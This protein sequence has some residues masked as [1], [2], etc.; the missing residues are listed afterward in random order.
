[1]KKIFLILFLM[2]FLIGTISALDF[3]NVAYYNENKKDVSI[4][5]AF[6]LPLIGY[7]IA[8][9]NLQTSLT[10]NFVSPGKDVIVFQMNIENYADYVNALKDLKIINMKNGKQEDKSYKWVY[11][12]YENID[13][14]DYDIKCELIPQAGKLPKEVCNKVIIGKHKENIIV[15]WKELI[16]K[17]LPKGNITIGLMTDVEEGDHYD[18]IPTLFGK[19]L[20]EWVEWTADLNTN[21]VHYWKLDDGNSTNIIDALY[22]VNGTKN[23]ATDPYNITGKIASAQY[24]HTNNYGINFSSAYVKATN[25]S[26]SINFWLYTVSNGG[27]YGEF[28]TSGHTGTKSWAVTGSGSAGANIKLTKN[29]L[30]EYSCVAT[31]TLNQ[32]TMV[33]ITMAPNGASNGNL[34]YYING[35]ANCSEIMAP[36]FGSTSN[37]GHI[38]DVGSGG[39]GIVASIDEIGIWVNRTLSASDINTLWNGGNGMSYIFFSPGVPVITLNSPANNYNSSSNS[40][41]FNCTASSSIYKIQNISL[42]INNNRNYTKTYGTSNF[43]ELNITRNFADGNFN[44]TCSADNNKTITDTGWAG[45]NRT[46]NIDTIKPIINIT[47]PINYIKYI[48]SGNN[49]SL[50]WS[51]SDSH[52]QSC[53]YTYNVTANISVPCSDNSTNI[54]VTSLSINNATIWANDTF[55]NIA[56]MS[57]S[58]YYKVFQ[59]NVSYS[60]TTT[61][62]AT[63]SFVLD[64]NQGGGLQTSIINLIYNTTSYS[65]TY[66]VS[67]NNVY[68]SNS[69]AIPNKDEAIIVPFYWKIILSDGSIINTTQYNQ[70]VSILSLDNC[71]DFSTVIYNYTLFDEETQNKLSNNIVELQ[72]NWYDA[73]KTV[74]ILNFSK[75]YEEE[76]KNILVCFNSSLLTNINYSVDSVVRYTSNDSGNSYSIKYYNILNQLITN[77]TIP[78]NVKLYDL[79]SSKSTEFQL[80]YKDEKLAFAPNILIYVYRQYV[81]DNDFK[82]VEIPL[83]DSNGQ[84]VLHLVRN[85]VIYNFVMINS[86]GDIVATFNRIIAFCQDY[87]IGSCSI[88]LNAVSQ[89]ERMY[90]YLDDLG[91]SYTTPTYS[92]TTG[93]ISFEFVSSNLS[94]VTTEMQVVRNNQFGNRSV[95]SNSFTSSSGTVSCNVSGVSATDRYL[96]IDIYVNGDLKAETT[97]DLEQSSTGG[98]GIV[99][100]AFYGFLLLLLMIC[101]FMDDKQGLVIALGIGWVLIIALTM[102]NGA[103]I[104]SI[105]GGIWL[106]LTIIMFIWK[107]KKEETG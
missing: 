34:T 57:R 83:T 103:I 40:V 23:I 19:E 97:I 3:D 79:L 5:N 28:L 10:D 102:I 26:F 68:S 84:T 31:Y 78:K 73:S 63:E 98:F 76:T 22:H 92:N 36:S 53:W 93:M 38:G 75:K 55:G 14:E 15:D 32:W 9:I 42:W 65:S 74:K 30:A 104:G 85:N 101:F 72:I 64:F 86:D 58:W 69:I 105:S 59:N 18:G 107:L 54:N 25:N 44:W 8:D 47:Y 50:N 77:S 37:V 87:T 39:T 67:S 16:G 52:L 35:V 24:F 94:T 51:V 70:T 62:G 96:F 60:A 41:A 48:I 82:V 6:D 56:N 88:N 81:A 91:I 71:T 90:N 106:I 12:V 4:Y 80:T 7:K 33:T 11:A 100:G 27:N 61:E 46:F 89:N 99:N 20:T 29:G 2:I 45:S 66:I 13:V 21:L 17:D 95:C 1:M 43:S 49:I